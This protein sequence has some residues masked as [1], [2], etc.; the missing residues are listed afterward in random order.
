[1]PKRRSRSEECRWN[2]D[3]PIPPSVCRRTCIDDDHGQQVFPDL[4]PKPKQIPHIAIRHR[5]TQLHFH[6]DH[7]LIWPLHDEVNLPAASLKVE[8]PDSRLGRLGD[9]TVAP[10]VAQFVRSRGGLGP[11][12]LRREGGQRHQRL[13]EVAQEGAISGNPW[14]GFHSAQK[15]P[16]IQPQEIHRQGGVGEMMLGGPRQATEEVPGWEPRR[17]RIKD[18]E[19]LQNLSVRLDRGLGRLFSPPARRGIPDGFE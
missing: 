14:N 2:N 17:D 1:M 7:P 16:L 3:Y 12:D 11:H 8:M 19:A 5:G 6:G 10:A 13:E 9:R 4:I 15:C 18:P